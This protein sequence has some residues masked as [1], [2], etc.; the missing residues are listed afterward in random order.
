MN[1]DPVKLDLLQELRWLEDQR[2]PMTDLVCQ[3]CDQNSGTHN[4]AGLEIVKQMLCEQFGRLGG[5]LNLVDSQPWVLTDELGNRTEQPLGQAIHIVKYPEAE[6][7][8]MLC[9]HMD[10]VYQASHPFQKCRWLND[11]RLNGPGVA[12][13]KGGAVVMLHALEALEK[14]SL[15]GRIGWEVILNPD[16][17]IGSPGSIGLINQRAGHCHVGLLFEPTLP[18]GTLISWR[19]G[20]GNFSFVARGQAAHSGRDFNAGRNA[21]V[22][23]AKLIQDIDALNV[24]DDVTYNVG[25]VEGGGALNTVPDLAIA[26]VNVRVRTVDQLHEVENRFSELASQYSQLNGITLTH[27]GQFASPPK[28]LDEGTQQLQK[29]IENCG[30][31]LGLPIQWQGTGGASD[32]NKFSAA[33]LPN[34]DTFGPRGG[35]IHSTDEFLETASLVPAAKLAALVLLSLAAEH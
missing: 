1:G 29:R 2:S 12:D 7:K 21:I 3:L 19:K 34:I 31:R 8:V 13:A 22:A 33:G 30:E 28:V 11:D 35:A 14:S 23:L 15:A 4:L 27:H 16:E 17:E 24:D 32:G 20:S 6:F 25:R 9:I 18:D 5:S 10:T 26:R